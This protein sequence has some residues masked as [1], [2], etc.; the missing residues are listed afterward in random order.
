MNSWRLI[1]YA[2]IAAIIAS[3]IVAGG[4]LAY[5][6]LQHNPWYFP[7][8]ETEANRY[9]QSLDSYLEV[10]QTA[11]GNIV[12]HAITLFIWLMLLP[13]WARRKLYP[14]YAYISTVAS[15]F[16]S[17][18]FAWSFVLLGNYQWDL[19]SAQ[20]GIEHDRVRY[21]V[22]WRGI[23]VPDYLY[24]CA[25]FM[26]PITAVL[27]FAWLS[28]NWRPPEEGLFINSPPGGV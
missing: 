10:F 23:Y 5:A 22:F 2:G 20:V 7:G 9:P 11:L 6:Y 19:A 26:L 27:I 13:F 3:C 12:Q 18:L 17:A 24:I 1:V 8:A 21:V 4:I 28:R 25:Y 16:F 15:I 14:Q